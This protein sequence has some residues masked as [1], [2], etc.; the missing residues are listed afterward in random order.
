MTFNGR[1]GVLSE[2]SGKDIQMKS[3]WCLVKPIAEA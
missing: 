1:H 2:Q 3:S